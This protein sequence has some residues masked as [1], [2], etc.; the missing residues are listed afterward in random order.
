[1]RGAQSGLIGGGLGAAIPLIGAALKP[2]GQ[3]AG[4]AFHKVGEMTGLSEP[5]YQGMAQDELSTALARDQV[6]PADIASQLAASGGKPVTAMDVGGTNTQRLARKL[7]TQPERRGQDNSIL[8]ER[9]Q[10]QG[11]R[12]LGDIT[13]APIPE[14]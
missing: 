9:S 8:S 1:M 3:A 5:N 7:V 6:N 2:V 14:Y 11:G 12:V 4:N 13:K 10:D